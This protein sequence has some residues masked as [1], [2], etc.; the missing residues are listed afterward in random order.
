MGSQSQWQALEP[1]LFRAPFLAYSRPM[2]LDLVNRLPL[3]ELGLATLGDGCHR[4]AHFGLSDGVFAP[5]LLC[6]GEIEIFVEPI[7]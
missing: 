5:G 2:S 7:V 6:G 4:S 1:A 3:I